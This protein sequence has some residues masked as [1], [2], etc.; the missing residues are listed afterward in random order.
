[1]KK[2]YSKLFLMLF[3]AFVTTAVFATT[4]PVTV[5][6]YDSQ[7]NTIAAKFKI[8]KGPNY[9]GEFD[10]GTIANLTVGHTYKLFA[11]YQSTST[12]RVTFV[13]TATGNTFNYSTTNVKF[14]WSGNYLDYRGD[15][16]WKSFGK[17]NGVWNDRELFPNDFYGNPM[18]IQ[19]GKVW[20]DPQTKVITISYAGDIN[21]HK[22]AVLLNL[23]DHNGNPLANGYARGG[24]GSAIQFHV[25]GTSNP[26]DA[27]G[28][29]FYMG[30]GNGTNMIF[31]MRYNGTH[32][33]ITQDVSTNSF[34]DFK[35]AQLKV[36]M[37]T[38]AGN[39]VDNGYVRF[40]PS[41]SPYKYWLDKNVWGNSKTGLLAPGE[42]AG[43]VFPGTYD[44]DMQFRYAE[45]TNTS[46]IVP[47]SGAMTTFKTKTVI[48]NYSN[49]IKYS[50]Q[51]GTYKGWFIKPSM[52]LLPAD[53]TFEF[54][55]GS[56]IDVTIGSCGNTPPA[57]VLISSGSTVRLI[58]SQGNG[59]AGG[60]VKYYKSGWHTAGVTD[61]NGDVVITATGLTGNIPFRMKWKGGSVQKSQNLANNST[62]IFQTELVTA[63]LN[64]STGADLN[65]KFK[66]YASGWKV[67]GNGT[68]TTMASMELLGRSY[69]F[70]VYYAGASIQKS[71][72]VKLDNAVIFKTTAVTAELN[73]SAGADLNAKFKYYA[74]GWKTFDSTTPSALATME[75]LPRNYP[76]RAYY[77]GASKQKSQNV[78]TDNSVDFTTVLV[79]ADLKDCSGTVLT[80]KF[81]YYASGWKTFDSTTPSTSASM[82]LLPR[83]YPFRVYFGG[84][85]KQKSQNVSV[86]ANV[87][88]NATNVTLS[89]PGMIKY[90]ASGWKLFKAAGVASATVPMLERTYPFRFY[91]A[92]NKSMKRNITVAGCEMN[93]G[94]IT[95]VDE[96]GA[97]LANYPADYPSETRNLKFKYRCGGSWAA[98]TNFQTDAN[99][100]VFYNINCANNNWDNKITMVLNQKSLE[101]DVTVNSIFQAAK[102][103]VNLTTCNG[104]ITD[105]P[106]GTVKQG[107]GYWYTHGTT[108]STGIVSLYTFPTN[109]L[110]L[111][112]NYNHGT[113]TKYPVIT[114]GT[115]EVDFTTTAL[116]LN[117]PN[118]DI[119]SNKGGSW[120]TFAQPTMNLLPGV[121]NFKFE[122]G[123]GWTSLYPITVTGCSMS[124]TLAN[125]TLKDANGNGIAGG[126]CTFTP[127]GSNW[128]AVGTTDASGNI[129]ALIPADG[130]DRYEMT[131]KG[132]KT[133]KWH[134]M[135]TGLT[136]EFNTVLVTMR[137]TD[138]TNDY[139]GTTA[140]YHGNAGGEWLF[141]SGTTT[142]SMEMLD[143]T[144]LIK[145]YVD[146]N[147]STLVKNNH[148][149]SVDG[150][151]VL[152][153]ISSSPARRHIVETTETIK[154]NV[155]P[156]P[157]K[158]IANFSFELE[159]SE[160]VRVVI[161]N[162]TG[163]IVSTLTD[164]EY[165]AG[166]NTISWNGTN[167]SGEQM[168]NG[169][170][171]Y[172][173]ETANNVI[174]N[175]IVLNK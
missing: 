116:T 73:N 143:I 95:L 12:A 132:Q 144:N 6:T 83:N 165:P 70:R 171:F 35:T 102:V 122:T 72:N 34:F 86:D 47:V 127:G 93:G 156:N 90:Y 92:S 106:G 142:A 91:D 170:Y 104:L 88:F 123:S 14:N 46:V 164:Q 118:G 96:T 157:F 26:T 137:I 107:G 76:F 115:N 30:S 112:M 147:G 126:V 79:T 60:I 57:P 161:Y 61:A 113:Q 150:Y 64:S 78:S 152:F 100:Q 153:T 68:A 41:Y 173:I 45:N 103:N 15:G 36:R 18:Q 111:R 81:K 160:T 44:V 121:Y 154:T 37:E 29:I 66:Y 69:P 40:K 128:Q 82:E 25:G 114:A 1:M 54:T 16:S 23:K 20:N 39:P 67:F 155:Y 98:W 124:S 7:G 136:L 149:Y 9:V 168:A 8:F 49:T 24:Y 125:V 19:F 146:Y 71:Q 38:C 89:H 131:Y 17:T 58:D 133:Q 139:T 21:F 162:I 159:E 28:N 75:L 3:L 62:V 169:V 175:K 59:L 65:A 80:T 52:E 109:S 151:E 53:Y 48:T 84:A 117:N 32:Q 148:K 108:A 138:G 166:V 130:L 4:A 77:A 134:K 85:S 158:D 43:E 110:K 99:G 5:N 174:T 51:G 94:I 11:H 101:Q 22:T 135:S 167:S 31:E 2:N 145:F 63:E 87:H 140:M 13:V 42:V 105:A 97:P 56:T 141:A 120:W 119:K 10:A 27:S 33:T 55:G 129:Y 172:T 50:L 163:Q 74:S